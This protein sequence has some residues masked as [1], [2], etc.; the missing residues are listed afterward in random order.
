MCRKFDK[1]HLTFNSKSK[2][3]CDAFKNK[4]E[5]QLTSVF[6]LSKMSPQYHIPNN[7]F[8]LNF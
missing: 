8:Q 1:F 5:C 7:K 4:N 6:F 2:V 3:S